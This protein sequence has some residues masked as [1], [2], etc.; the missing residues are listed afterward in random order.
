MKGT[1]N[2]DQEI[3][4]T[5]RVKQVICHEFHVFRPF[6][7]DN[8]GATTEVTQKLEFVSEGP[9][10]RRRKGKAFLF[11]F[12]VVVAATNKFI[13]VAFYPFFVKKQLS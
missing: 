10:K 8:S 12:V 4:A 1:H 13:A 2:C 6:S 7:K 5:G 3:S 9:S 11:P